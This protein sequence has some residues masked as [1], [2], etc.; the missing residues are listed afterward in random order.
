MAQ[1]WP[2]Q[3]LWVVLMFYKRAQAHT[4]APSFCLFSLLSLCVCFFS[5]CFL[6]HVVVFLHF[7][8]DCLWA[9]VFYL[10][11]TTSWHSFLALVLLLFALTLLL[12]IFAMLFF[13]FPQ[14][15]FAFIALLLV[16]LL[17]FLAFVVLLLT[18]VLLLLAFALLLII[19]MPLL[20]AF[21]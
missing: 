7:T 15:I 2:P 8:I 19:F 17:L 4:W 1:T 13:T 18:F 5:H 11:V 14:F 12:L 16:L 9:F 21:V 3:T 6:P 20:L 10:C